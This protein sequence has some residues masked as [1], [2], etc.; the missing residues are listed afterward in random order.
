MEEL[1]ELT[2][3]SWSQ[4]AGLVVFALLTICVWRRCFSPISDVPGPVVASCTRF[5][6]I[7]HI[8]KGDQNLESIRLH[9]KHGHFVRIAPNEVSVSHPDATKKVLSAPLHKG[10]W[11]KVVAFPD[12]RFVNPM[13]ATDPKVKNELS[14]HLAP[15]YTLTNL[16]QSEDS[17]SHVIELLLGWLD[18]YAS[19]GE[20]MDL[21]KFFTYATS[22][23]IGEL[24]FSK[25][26]GFLREGRDI[27]GAI[28]SAHPQAAYV[29]VAGFFRWA[30]VLFLSNPV[31]IRL[32][33]TPWGHIID[34]AM[35]AIKERQANPDACF[36]A[37]AHWFRMLEQHPDRMQLHEIHSAAFNAV[38]AG[39]ETVAAGLQA[40]VYLMIRHP[41]TWERA[42]A[43]IDA[44][45]LSRDR[46][47]SFADAHALPYL[48]ACIKEALRIFSPAPMGLPRVAPKGGLQIGDRTLPAGTIASVNVWVIHYSKEIWGPDAREFNPDRWMSD[49]ALRLDKYFIPWGLGYASCPGQNIAK[50]ELS[51]IC[52]TLVRDYNI[53]QVDPKQEWSWKAY[54]TVV[55][56]DWPCYVEKRKV[57]A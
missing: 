31:I 38:A 13:S 25:Q 46:V 37:A 47:I 16:L 40:F 56:H 45:G 20:A 3:L 53:R 2:G 50:I 18:K 55:P 54:F 21:D 52:A 24:V 5:W 23:V 26:F 10:S 30:H 51:K 9:D 7:W 11:Y 39:N 48:Q 15:A 12:G 35:A 43:E 41:G 14:R 4:A 57:E 6:H 34:T 8:L 44:A 42:G 19:T 36:D 1:K 33:I 28:A 27:G 22:D 17:I 29:A 32:G 49:D